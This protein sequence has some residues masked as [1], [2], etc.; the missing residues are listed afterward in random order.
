MK[1]MARALQDRLADD[2]Q[3]LFQKHDIGRDMTNDQVLTVISIKLI[4]F[5]QVLRFYPSDGKGNFLGKLQPV[6]QEA[7]QPILLIC[8]S[9]VECETMS[10]NPRSLL[11]ATKTR[12][13]PRVTLIK[14]FIMH[15]NVLVLTGKCP[16]CLTLYHADHERTPD[17]MEENQWNR[18]YLNS[19]KHFKV[20][21]N[22]WVDR[23]FSNAV[24][25]GMYSFHASAAAYTEFWNNSFWTTQDVRCQKIS[26]RQVWQAFVQESIRMVAAKSQLNLEL[27]DGLAIDEVAKEAFEVLGE[28]GIIRAADMHA[29]S[30]CTHTYKRTADI[31][32]GDDP[33]A[34]AGNDENRVVPPLVGED[35]EAAAH[36]AAE[37]R[38]HAQNQGPTATGQDMDVDHAP[39][40]MVI[41][42]GLV[43][44]PVV[45]VSAF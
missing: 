34:M 15:E 32:T 22:L 27:R 7:I 42:D 38:E 28:N 45:C 16:V 31:I 14:N 6:S 41:L 2:S 3:Q 35:A 19:A 11:Q 4:A 21:K 26:R 9:S 13:I 36:D 39:V 30:E 17:L 1:H 43:T 8:P 18:V 12:D 37:A 25:N 44:G 40:K 24:M 23:L 29:C 10:C 5:A 20:G 33:A